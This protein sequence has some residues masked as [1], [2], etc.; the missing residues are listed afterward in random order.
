M[1]LF[2]GRAVLSHKQRQ[3]EG[4]AA[5]ALSVPARRA[6]SSTTPST[7]VFC[8]L[9]GQW[10]RG[11][12]GLETS[13][14]TPRSA[15]QCCRPDPLISAKKANVRTGSVVQR[16]SADWV[17]LQRCSVRPAVLYAVQ[18]C[19]I[20]AKAVLNTALLLLHRIAP[21]TIAHTATLQPSGWLLQ[22]LLYCSI[23]LPKFTSNLNIICNLWNNRSSR[24]ISHIWPY[25]PSGANIQQKRKTDTGR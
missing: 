13:T 23:F 8:S 25:L 20:R 22:P 6:A 7:L 4:F 17:S 16:L 9:G 21:P 12:L 14:D 24:F 5:G 2:N 18:T 15:L 1:T 11:N 10:H 19:S 3:R